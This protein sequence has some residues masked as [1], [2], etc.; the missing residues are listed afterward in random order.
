VIG[1]LMLG[2][3]VG[4]LSIAFQVWSVNRVGAR[5]SA[6]GALMWLL[7]GMVLRL[8]GIV[9]LFGLALQRGFTIGLMAFGGLWLARWI[10]LFCIHKGYVWPSDAT[11]CGD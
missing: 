3:L 11:L 10:A 2:W 4:W 5:S 8:G 7:G 6:A 9:V 1:W